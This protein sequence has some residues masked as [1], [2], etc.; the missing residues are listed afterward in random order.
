MGN[1]LRRHNFCLTIFPPAEDE[2]DDRQQ[3]LQSTS[4]DAQR[5]HQFLEEKTAKINELKQQLI[6]CVDDNDPPQI[7]DQIKYTMVSSELGAVESSVKLM[8]AQYAAALQNK[9]LLSCADVITFSQQGLNHDNV[10]NTLRKCQNELKRT[11]T[12]HKVANARADLADELHD[13][14]AIAE[15]TLQDRSPL[16]DHLSS[17]AGVSVETVAKWKKTK[18]PERKKIVPKAAVTI[19]VQP[20]PLTSEPPPP[21]KIKPKTKKGDAVVVMEEAL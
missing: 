12:D 2:E 11:V 7:T 6:A 20:A 15:E 13:S 10:L 8:I 1:F 4:I 17:I 9:E 14:T 3:L 19:P 21:K 18:K 16:D 5:Y